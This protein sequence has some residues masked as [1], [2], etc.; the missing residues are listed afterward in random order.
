[1]TPDR[2]AADAQ[3]IFAAAVDR[4]RPA[5]LFDAFDWAS[6][7]SRPLDQYERVIVLAAGKASAAMVAAL[8]A[9]IGRRIDTGVAVVPTAYLASAPRTDGVALVGGGHPV[10]QA[11][12]VEAATH[13]LALAGSATEA[14]LVLVLLSGG[15]SALWTAPAA[16]LT[17]HDVQQTNR[18]LLHGNVPIHAINAV[19]KHLSR[20]KGGRLAQA[21]APAEV[22]AL[23]LS[24]VIGDDL[25]AIASGPTVPDPTTYADARRILRTM[26]NQG[27][28][29]DAVWQHVESGIADHLGDT[30]NA[31]LPRTQTH[32]IG[33]NRMALAAARER[34]KTLG[35][36]TT[37]LSHAVSGVAQQVGSEQAHQL[38]S[39]HV[40][41]PTC[42]L[43]GGETTVHVR[44]AGRGGR[45]QELALAAALA[46]DG[47]A[48]PCMLL[49]GGTDGIDGPTP[50]AGA[51]ASPDTCSRA[52]H[53]GLDAAAF[54]SDNDAF[55]FFER[56]G[57]LLRIGPTH[58][59]VMDVQVGLVWPGQDVHKV[60]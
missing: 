52:R 43:W 42:Y 50:A 44:G 2:L 39:Q 18:A 6:T 24:D 57:G 3:S 8:H 10:P 34:A 53:L 49:S 41:Q 13:A 38:L 12:S 22:R 58:T 21:A 32:L 14:D 17:L 47:A 4:V 20:I 19:R 1:M 55:T 23:V 59:N 9:Q 56:V 30:P 37:V 33:T 29:P 25:T 40:R 36:Q 11:G 51:I 48:H 46:L 15:G 7:L 5:R 27:D 31:A 28:V 16:G 60:V 35:Y 26:P 45:N 54:L